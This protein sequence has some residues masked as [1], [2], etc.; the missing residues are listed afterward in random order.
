MAQDVPNTSRIQRT[1][2]FPVGFHAL[3]R[4]PIINYQLNRWCSFG[5][6]P[7]DGLRAVG[8]RVHR[9]EDLQPELTRWAEEALAQNR[10]EIAC[11]ALR[12]AEFF[13]PHE[14][15]D[16]RALYERFQALFYGDAFGGD[17]LERIDVP[18]PGGS[19]PLLRVPARGQRRGMIV[20]HG[21]FDSFMEELYPWACAF[22]ARGYEAV[23][24]EGPGQGGALKRS[25]LTLDWAW[26]RPARAVLD[27]L[28]AQDVA[29]LGVSMGGWLCF[30][31]AA[32]EPRI[33]RVIASSVAFD[34]LQIPPRPVAWFARFC[35]RY[36][37]L[38]DALARAKARKLPRERWGLDNV[39]AI[40]GQRS[41][42][43]AA[44]YFLQMNE[45]NLC[46][47]AV[48]QDV[49][50]QT[51]SEDSFI[52]MKIH[53]KQIEALTGARSVTGRVFYP[54]TCAHN[55]CQVGNTGLALDEMAA[56]IERVS[57]S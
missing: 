47:P 26:E 43:A 55:H 40:T 32:H 34:Y 27:H 12:G 39:L 7:L 36:P 42:T 6:L 29:W 15:P 54:D 10:P 19:L 33:R 31:A 4:V 52:P 14:H 21:G 51:G 25:G 41:P 37:R 13:V 9:L 38:L 1:F 48:R 17:E 18:Y 35:L 50:I 20:I 22:A 44:R 56:W 16:K 24:F 8:A 57:G 28:G 30:R 49:L 53:H 45:E 5:L 11:F 23:L 3:T 46:A 2:T